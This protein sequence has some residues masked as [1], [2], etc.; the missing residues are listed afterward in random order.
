MLR[1]WYCTGFSMK[2]KQVKDAPYQ[3]GSKTLYVPDHY[4][5][6]EINLIDLLLVLW[7]WKWFIAL[8]P[9]VAAVGAGLFVFL[10]PR[11]YE[12]NYTYD[13]K[14]GEKELKTLE[15]RFYSA[16]NLF[17]FTESL[18]KKGFDIYSDKVLQ[19]ESLKS[20]Q[21]FVRFEISPFYFKSI[22]TI[23]SKELDELQKI[24]QLKGSLLKMQLRT[25]ER[26]KIREIAHIARDVFEK[27]MFFY[28]VRRSLNEKVISLKGELADI[29]EKRY[30]TEKQLDRKKSTLE[31][32]KTTDVEELGGLPKDIVLQFNNIGANSAYL[33]LPYQIQAAKTQLINLQEQMEATK[34]NYR[35]YSALLALEEEVFAFAKSLVATDGDFNQFHEFLIQQLKQYEQKQDPVKDYLTAY[36]KRIENKQAG[37]VPL[38]EIPKVYALPR[39]TLKT[40]ALVFVAVFVLSVFGAFF[41]EGL[42]KVRERIKEEEK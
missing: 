40:V 10:Q 1:Y 11:L 28:P 5:E 38:V 36:I 32:L 29:E 12:I 27:V 25:N 26:E 31:I 8:V 22:D 34:E 7:R 39:N 6:D 17:K 37:L 41:F 20:L 3:T 19:T 23:E 33:P 35:Y 13:M 42:K 15:D 9:V 2:Q 18:K 21:S 30:T 16:E 4:Q 24:Q 14:L